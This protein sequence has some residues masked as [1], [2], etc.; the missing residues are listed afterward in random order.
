M[1]PPYKFTYEWRLFE[2]NDHDCGHVIDSTQINDIVH[3]TGC[4]FH[5][6]AK[7][8]CIEF[9]SGKV[10]KKILFLMGTPGVDMSSIVALICFYFAIHY[11]RPVLWHRKRQNKLE[12]TKQ[13]I[14]AV[15]V[16]DVLTKLVA[17]TGNYHQSSSTFH[18][19][20]G[21]YIV[22]W[23]GRYDVKNFGVKYMQLDES[24]IDARL[25]VS[26]G[27]VSDFVNDNARDIV[28][29][30]LKYIEIPQDGRYLLQ[31][32]FGY[33]EVL[34]RIIMVGVKN[35]DNWDGFKYPQYF[36]MTSKL[37]LQHLPTIMYFI[38]FM[39][40]AQ[41]MDDNSLKSNAFEFVNYNIFECNTGI[42]ESL[43]LGSINFKELLTIQWQGQIQNECVLSMEQLASIPTM[44]DYWIPG[45]SLSDTIDTVAKS[46]DMGGKEKFCFIQLTKD[47]THKFK[48][49]IFWVFVQPFL[50]IELHV[51]YMAIIAD[52]EKVSK[53][54]LNHV[55]TMKEEVAKCIPFYVGYCT[56]IKTI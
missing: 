39:S 10:V 46:K 56:N 38:D 3:F 7:K 29:T 16:L 27:N 24:E 9:E 52:K 15:L 47:N 41:K 36:C 19:V 49:E 5:L 32:K 21:P 28:N 45:T 37:A 13:Y 43:V 53:F 33:H 51:C 4:K 30:A 23:W 34:D 35:R 25:Y 14:N 12:T 2:W 17:S 22:S 26:N 48:S 54:Q 8:F 6:R 40:A 31:K 11:N 1:Q 20:Q 18:L 44:I 55:H 42:V 50:R